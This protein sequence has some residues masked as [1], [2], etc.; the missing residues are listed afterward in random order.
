M[1]RV[2]STRRSHWNR[3]TLEELLWPPAG[4]RSG[5][6]RRHTFPW[7]RPPVCLQF[8]FH[9]RAPWQNSGVLLCFPAHSPNHQSPCHFLLKHVSHARK[10]FTSSRHPRNRVYC[11]PNSISRCSLVAPG[12]LCHWQ[13]GPDDW[14][15][16]GP[17]KRQSAVQV[18]ARVHP[19]PS[20]R[21]RSALSAPLDLGPETCSGWAVNT[22]GQ[23]FP[24]SQPLS[25]LSPS[26]TFELA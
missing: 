10:E 23:R 17:P 16:T 20:S 21:V 13:H 24:V 12:S 4:G 3:A 26:E 14:D 2:S 9:H 22:S 11:L 6:F 25:C 19:A 18:C 8:G 15:D 7:P 1:F 5:G